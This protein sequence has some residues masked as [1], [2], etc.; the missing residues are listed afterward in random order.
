MPRFETETGT[1]FQTSRYSCLPAMCKTSTV[2]ISMIIL[3]TVEFILK[4]VNNSRLYRV[5]RKVRRL[6]FINTTEKPV[7]ISGG[8][9]KSKTFDRF[10]LIHF[11]MNKV[12][13]SKNC[14]KS[15][16]RRKKEKIQHGIMHIFVS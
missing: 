6:P 13:I 8:N 14:F 1:R 2:V 3:V 11:T 5:F 4:F 16:L 10:Y 9:E 7:D 12:K 15:L